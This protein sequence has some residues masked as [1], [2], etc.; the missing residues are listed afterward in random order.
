[1]SASAS[2]N[3]TNLIL[4]AALGIGAYW[5]LTRRAQAAPVAV[6]PAAGQGG[7]SNALANANAIGN[8]VGTVAGLFRGSGSTPL[9]GTVDG[10]SATQWDVTPAGPGGPTYNNPSAYVSSALDGLAFNPPAGSAYDSFAYAT[11]GSN[12]AWWN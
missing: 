12:G 4:L 11:D 9:L 3:P 6:A 10:R 7:G 5:M 1:M 2:P 8:L